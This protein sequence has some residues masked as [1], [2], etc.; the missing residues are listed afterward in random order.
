MADIQTVGNDTLTGAGIGAEFGGGYGAAIGAAAGFVVGLF[1]GGGDNNVVQA[2]N[3]GGCDNGPRDDCHN[4]GRGDHGAQ[5]F[6]AAAERHADRAEDDLQDGNIRG[7]KRE[8]GEERLDLQL[9]QYD[10]QF[11]GFDNY[12]DPRYYA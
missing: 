10:S 6:L 4:H 1:G 2:N 8:L 12:R 3:Q 11:G 7:A 5:R 9:A